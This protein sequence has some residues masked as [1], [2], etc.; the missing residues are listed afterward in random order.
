M[1]FEVNK[2]LNQEK[3]RGKTFQKYKLLEFSGFKG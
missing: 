2:K 3:F 1:L